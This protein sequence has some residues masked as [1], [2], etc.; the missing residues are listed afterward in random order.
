MMMMMMMMKFQVKGLMKF[1]SVHHLNVF[2]TC[3]FS[4]TRKIRVQ[5]WSDI[6]MR[7]SWLQQNSRGI[8]C[9]REWTQSLYTVF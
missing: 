5:H 9:I 3:M 1:T 8:P 6:M 7:L 2:Y 4:R